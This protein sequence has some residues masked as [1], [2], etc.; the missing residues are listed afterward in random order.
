[1]IRK[2]YRIFKDYYIRYVDSRYPRKGPIDEFGGAYSVCYSESQQKEVFPSL[3][4]LRNK[5]FACEGF[6]EHLKKNQGKGLFFND[7]LAICPEASYLINDEILS[8]VREYLGDNVKLDLATLFSI[9]TEGKSEN[10]NTSGI[11]HHDSVGSRIKI[12]F[13]IN[14]DGNVAAPTEYIRDTH[15]NFYKDYDN[16]VGIDG[17]RLSDDLIKKNSKSLKKFVEPFGKA[18][19]IDTNGV[20][21]GVYNQGEVL[22]LNVLFEFSSKKSP[23]VRGYVGPREFEM[24][25]IAYK[26]LSDAKIIRQNLIQKGT[27]SFIHKLASK[28][29]NE[30]DKIRSFNI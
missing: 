13:S 19:V 4:R 26:F 10:K 29:Q 5:L 7:L 23:V 17:N 22:R 14:E 12:F 11:F 25:K 3:E 28:Q 15:K 21:R 20:H 1:M 6:L 30:A 18:L 24:G 9:Y 16:I 2:I 8:S 27:D